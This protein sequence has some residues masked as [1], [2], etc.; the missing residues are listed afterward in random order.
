MTTRISSKGQL[1][2]PASIRTQD[3]I[4][5]GQE[6]EIERVERGTYLLRR[7]EPRANEGLVDW[8]LSCPEKGALRPLDRS[9]TTADIRSPFA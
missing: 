9:E 2:L 4:L 7:A 8:L 5:A 3:E 1:V 6:F